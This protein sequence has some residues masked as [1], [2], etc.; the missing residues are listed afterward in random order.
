MRW[1]VINLV[2]RTYIG[3]SSRRVQTFFQRNNEI[4]VRVQLARLSKKRNGFTFEGL[5][6][7]KKR[8]AFSSTKRYV[9][10]AHGDVWLHGRKICHVLHHQSVHDQMRV[11]LQW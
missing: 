9:F 2:L 1:R 7:K 3:V 6:E 8:P 10:A 5:P 4:V 11:W